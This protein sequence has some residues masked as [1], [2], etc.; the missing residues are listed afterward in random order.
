ML[1]LSDDAVRVIHAVARTGEQPAPVGGVRLVA[2]NADRTGAVTAVPVSDPEPGDL[3]VSR[4]GATCCV[5][6][7]LATELTDKTLDA[8]GPDAGL[9]SD[10]TLV[11]DLLDHQQGGS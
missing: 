7:E 5:D 9:D 4:A 10:G 6:Q 8:A 1:T 2:L 11:F 3:V